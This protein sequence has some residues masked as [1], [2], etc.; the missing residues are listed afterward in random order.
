MLQLM[1]M[2]VLV[3]LIQIKAVLAMTF[4]WKNDIL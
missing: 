1:Q 4:Q 3:Q 2:D